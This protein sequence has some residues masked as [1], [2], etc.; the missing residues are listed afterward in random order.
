MVALDPRPVSP[1]NAFGREGE[2]KK[3]KG[4]GIPTIGGISGR[5]AV[6]LREADD[7]G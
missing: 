6:I 7:V 4:M 5:P 1:H 2:G 3:E